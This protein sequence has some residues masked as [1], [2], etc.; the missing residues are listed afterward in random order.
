[1]T[2]PPC[3]RI[4]YIE[5]EP[6]IRTVAQIALEEVGGFAV[7]LAC[8]GNEGIEMAKTFLPD[9]ILLDVMMPGMDGPSTLRALK[10]IPETAGIPVIFLTAKAQPKE[11][12]SY[13]RLGALDVLIKPFDPMTLSDE[14]RAIW[15]R[16]QQPP[17]PPDAVPAKTPEQRS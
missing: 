1:M 7:A 4:L 13:K 9:L 5:D 15:E 2:H 10:E 6:H 14:I 16:S 3:S 17:P 8:S 11:I 12:E